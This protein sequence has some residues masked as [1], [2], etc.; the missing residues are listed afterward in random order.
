MD[1]QKRE[2]NFICSLIEKVA[3]KYHTHPNPIARLYGAL[4]EVFGEIMARMKQ[5]REEEK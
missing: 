1:D 2:I 3:E 5:I 4:F